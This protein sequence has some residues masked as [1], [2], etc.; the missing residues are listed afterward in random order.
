MIHTAPLDNASF[1]S[2]SSVQRWKYVCQRR[3]ANEKELSK[4]DLDCEDIIEL[5]KVV[6][7]MNIVIDIDPCYVKLVNEFIMNISPDC[8]IEGI[9][10]YMNI[11]VRGKCVNFSPSIINNHL[12]KIKSLGSDKASSIDKVVKEITGGK[13]K[14]WL[15][16]D[17]LSNGRLSVKYVIINRIGVSNWEPTN[18]SSNVTPSLVKLIFQIGTNTKLN[19]GDYIFEQAMNHT[20]S[21]VV[22]LPI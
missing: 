3:V 12:G 1:C 16:K 2:E 22:K 11:Y 6:G 14:Q 10:E 19:F 18:H 13:V 15:N 5:L 9:Q 8:N 4:K 21:F 20:D 7:L 17:L